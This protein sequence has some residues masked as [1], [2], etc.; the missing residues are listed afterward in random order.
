M[1]NSIATLM[2]AILFLLIARTIIKS[3][4]YSGERNHAGNK[5]WGHN[6]WMSSCTIEIYD[7]DIFINP[8]LGQSY[9]INIS[10]IRSIG[11]INHL[12]QFV[13]I[14]YIDMNGELKIGKY[15][16]IAPNKFIEKVEEIRKS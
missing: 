8:D 11:Y 16:I 14:E 5:Y 7:N 9:V 13:R 4:R 15:D 6:S 1:K 3:I 10:T 2:T 12:F